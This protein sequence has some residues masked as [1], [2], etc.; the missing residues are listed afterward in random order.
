MCNDSN[1][2]RKD[3][4]WQTNGTL[5]VCLTSTRWWRTCVRVFCV[6][7]CARA[8]LS[9][10]FLLL[11]LV[12][13]LFLSLRR[14]KRRWRSLGSTHT[15][16]KRDQTDATFFPTIDI[17]FSKKKRNVYYWC[18]NVAVDC[19]FRSFTTPSN[20]QILPFSH[21]NP[22]SPGFSPCR[23]FFLSSASLAR[24]LSFFFFSRRVTSNL[25]CYISRRSVVMIDNIKH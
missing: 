18:W 14:K 4:Y 7:V 25:R 1:R 24:S 2:K 10:D 20:G 3:C 8:S 5:F 19:C 17:F 15:Y 11:L 21:S 9:W 6:C 16:K 23:F 13:F 12:F 22:L